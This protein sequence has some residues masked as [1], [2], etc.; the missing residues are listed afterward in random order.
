MLKK[1]LCLILALS[2]IGITGCSLVSKTQST[3]TT[4]PASVRLIREAKIS[5]IWMMKQLEVDLAGEFSMVLTLKDGDKV[6][7]YFY[8]VKGDNVAFN[9]SGVS[10]IYT[11]K[12]TDTETLR[13]TSDRFSITASQAQANHYTLIFNAAAGTNGKSNTTVFLE[14]IYPVTGTLLVPLGTGTK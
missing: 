13:I 11:S 10:P 2:L 3:N 9:I 7:G 4:T 5:K 12:S 14:I 1:I 6:E 8:L